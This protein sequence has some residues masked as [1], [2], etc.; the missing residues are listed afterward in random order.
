[1]NQISFEPWPD[2]WRILCTRPDNLG[3]VL[4]TTPAFRALKESFP[5]C[6]LTLLT[7]S[8][9]AAVARLIPEID[10][11][12]IFDVPWVKAS[13]QAADPS[14]LIDMADQL[15]QRQFDAAIVFT[16]QS[17]NP[18]PMAMLCYLAGIS[19]VLGYCRENPYQLLTNWL[20]DPEVLVATRHE[21]TRQLN[22]VNA[23]GANTMNK[24]LS[25]TLPLG[26]REA[27]RQTLTGTGVDL[28]QPWLLLH[29]GVTEEKRRYPPEQ[30]AELARRLIANDNIQI[31][32]TGN[33]SEWAYAEL[34][35]E[36]IGTGAFN[37][38]GQFDLPLFCALIAEAPLLVANNTG[39]V[40]IA[41]AVS[42]PVVVA[43]AKTNPQ[44]TP[45]MVS[46]RVLYME[47]AEPLRS[48]NVL[49]QQ[50]P[51]PAEPRA[52]PESL[53]E[54]IEKLRKET[55]GRWMTESQPATIS[56]ELVDT[57]H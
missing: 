53:L 42:T 35:R 21:V 30:F 25:L 52:T 20:P 14:A 18:L 50:F 26:V 51:E 8:A 22:L 56:N 41:A 10:E 43:Y 47:V 49:L 11:I 44:H 28:H 17:Q 9:G 24:R 38:A 37:V 57:I 15:R 34:I 5:T 45:W 48:R 7:S 39:P 36:Q 23:I 40:H 32:L 29:P 31:V 3:D 55:A 27:A 13:C 6:Q 16:V 1:M 12:I 46:N 4:M 2:G 33:Q 54:A 19:H